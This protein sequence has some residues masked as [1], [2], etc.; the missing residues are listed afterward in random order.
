MNNRWGGPNQQPDRWTWWP[1]KAC[2]SFDN[3]TKLRFSALTNMDIMVLTS[4]NTSQEAEIG[5]LDTA[6]RETRRRKRSKQN[7]VRI[8]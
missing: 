7:K 4:G 2:F 5:S 1:K 3:V 8:G 6:S